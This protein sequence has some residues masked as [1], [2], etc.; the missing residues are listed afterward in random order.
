MITQFYEFG[1]PGDNKTSEIQILQSGEW[2][3][4]SYGKMKISEETMNEMIRHFQ[5]K[6]R[7]GVYITEGHPQADEELPAVGWVKDLVKK[8]SD[9]LWAVIEWTDKGMELLKSK[10][11]KFFSPEF[12]FKYEDPETREKYDNVLTGGALTNRP[13]FKSLEAVVLSEHNLIT[14]KKD[15][16]IEKILAKEPGEITVAERDFL[17]KMK[18]DLD[19]ETIKKYKLDEGEETKEEEKKEGE[20]EKK[21]E[22]TEE[23]KE[24]ESKGGDEEE[25]EEEAEKQFSEKMKAVEAK[26]TE[27]EKEVQ[28]MQA[29]EK[30]R[31]IE[32]EIGK[33]TFSEVNKG[34]HFL[35]KGKDAV[36]KFCE[37]LDADQIKAFF[38]IVKEMPKVNMFGELGSGTFKAEAKTAPK[39][40]D[41]KSFDIDV[42]AKRLMSENDKLSYTDAV[43]AAEKT[44]KEAE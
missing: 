27:L 30:S 2:N 24:E 19:K 21:E 28:K 17:L 7:K 14:K 32:G 37:T 42:E 9:T 6:L 35:P 25:K 11:Y 5:N 33:F 38:E 18:D 31:M 13:Y 1:E 10:S 36:Q 22:E 26:N 29:A 12:Y 4:P 39:D 15:M 20:E 3:H 44:L 8:G 23:K 41:Q 34:G 40:M 16:E 43:V